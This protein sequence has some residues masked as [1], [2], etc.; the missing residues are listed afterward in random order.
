MGRFILR[1][2]P[3]SFSSINSDLWASSPYHFISK[4][5]HLKRKAV[6]PSIPASFWTCFL[7]AGMFGYKTLSSHPNLFITRISLKTIQGRCNLS[8]YVMLQVSCQLQEGVIL[9]LFCITTFKFQF[10]IKCKRGLEATCWGSGDDT[11]ESKVVESTE[12]ESCEKGMCTTAFCGNSSLSTRKWVF[13]QSLDLR[14]VIQSRGQFSAALLWSWSVHQQRQVVS[15]VLIFLRDLDLQH[16][17]S[18][19][20]GLCCCSVNEKTKT[21]LIELIVSK[22][23]TII[24]H[25]RAIH[26][27]IDWGLLHLDEPCPCFGISRT[28][29]SILHAERGTVSFKKDCR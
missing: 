4:I 28:E 10:S 25:E 14:T 1:I 15:W 22:E 24:D 29:L 16:E 6:F 20:V 12:L 13:R 21:K 7:Q 23:K 18:L 27:Y 8:Q 26:Y 19:V 17:E 3:A 11:S 5:P 2:T 9:F